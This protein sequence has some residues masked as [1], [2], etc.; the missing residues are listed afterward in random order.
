MI[1]WKEFF[2]RFLIRVKFSWIFSEKII[3]VREGEV[4]SNIYKIFSCREFPNHLHGHLSCTFCESVVVMTIVHNSSTFRIPDSY[5][6]SR[7]RVRIS[8][9]ARPSFHRAFVRPS[10]RPSDRPSTIFVSDL[11]ETWVEDR[12]QYVVHGIRVWPWFKVKVKVT[13][14]PNLKFGELCGLS[15][16]RIWIMDGN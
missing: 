14:L 3:R 15:R 6:I 10:V 13:S 11:N 2:I 9:I 12:G 7:H 8:F 16:P 4:G 1:F 5:C